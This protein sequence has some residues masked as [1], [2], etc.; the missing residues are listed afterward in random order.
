M[1]TYESEIYPAPDDREQYARMLDTALHEFSFG[2]NRPA[3]YHGDWGCL[4]VCYG[5]RVDDCIYQFSYLPREAV[6]DIP[7]DIRRSLVM[8]EKIRDSVGRKALDD[9]TL[10]TTDWYARVTDAS[11]KHLISVEILEVSQ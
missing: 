1:K 11:E 6:K 9:L 10:P 2:T 3:V 4:T 5:G 8:A 7:A